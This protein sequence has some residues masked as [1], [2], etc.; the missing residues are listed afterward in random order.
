MKSR[1]RS[2][3]ALVL[4]AG[5]TAETSLSTVDHKIY[6]MYPHNTSNVDVE[7]HDVT[8]M[9]TE[10][11]QSFE[12]SILYRYFLRSFHIALNLYQ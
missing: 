9:N 1:I 7:V 8:P 11:E 5:G 2:K 3:M 4:E 10:N 6:L 12:V